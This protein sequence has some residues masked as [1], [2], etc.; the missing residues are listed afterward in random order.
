M[1]IDPDEIIEEDTERRFQSACPNVPSQLRTKKDL[2]SFGNTI[3]QGVNKLLGHVSA[4]TASLSGA[5]QTG[6][7]Y[8]QVQS[9]CSKRYLIIIYMFIIHI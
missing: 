6:G 3:R 1:L 7:G 2:H 4:I 9:Q 8:I 5:S